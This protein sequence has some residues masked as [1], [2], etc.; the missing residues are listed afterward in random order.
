MNELLDDQL[1]QVERTI[2]GANCQPFDP[3][4]L[5]TAPTNT[6]LAS[7][8]REVDVAYRADADRVYELLKNREC[9]ATE[10]GSAWL[11]LQGWFQHLNLW[12]QNV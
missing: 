3:F 7:A 4:S 12:K 9:I 10:K 11:G 8:R 1:K 6:V 2:F 5:P